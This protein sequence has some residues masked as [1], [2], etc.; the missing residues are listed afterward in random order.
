MNV[1]YGRTNRYYD[2]YNNPSLYHHYYSPGGLSHRL[3]NPSVL[4]AV[5]VVGLAILYQTKGEFVYRMLTIGTRRLSGLYGGGFGSKSAGARREPPGLGNMNNSCYQNSI[6]QSLSS[7]K[8]LPSYLSAIP[9]DPD[10]GR[11][12]VRTAD[13]LRDFLVELNDPANNGRT[14]WTPWVLK[15]MNSWQQQDAQEYYSKILEAVDKDITKAAKQLRQTPS[16]DADV[17]NDDAA[18]PNDDAAVS[19]HSEDSG[20]QS[21]LPPKPN[22]DALLSRNPLE[23]LIAQRVACV[24]CG[25]CD[26]LSTIPFNC[27]TLNL[28]VGHTQHDL[29]ERLDNYTKVEDINGV[30]C[31]KCSLISAQTTIKQILAANPDGYP[32]MRERLA[33]V[34]QALEEDSFDDKTLKRCKIS[35]KPV[36]T[37]KTKQ[38]VIARPPRSL[39]VH[40]SR[41]VFDEQTGYLYKNF[42]PV[43]FPMRL[44]L[45]PWCLGSAGSHDKLAV[46]GKRSGVRHEEQWLVHPRESMVAGSTRPSKI[47]GPIYELRAVVTHYGAHESGHYICYKRT[48][49][50]PHPEKESSEEAPPK[51]ASEGDEGHADEAVIDEEAGE[52]KAV[53]KESE[54]KAADKEGEQR[55]ETETEEA[56]PELDETNK[57]TTTEKEPQPQWWRISDEDVCPVDE[58]EVLYQGSAVFMLFYDCVDPN[59]TLGMEAKGNDSD[60]PDDCVDPNPT[61]LGMEADNSDVSDDSVLTPDDSVLTPDDS[62]VDAGAQQPATALA[63]SIEGVMLGSVGGT[64]P[65][66]KEDEMVKPA[67]WDAAADLAAMVPLPKDDW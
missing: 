48:V 40:I 27:L 13:T 35:M 34:D 11:S 29:A 43:Q 50:S 54:E 51:L 58:Q 14:L 38:A 36:T 47:K 3:T 56:V 53:D 19:Q 17:P 55:P 22:I 37:T 8:D 4:L 64:M 52:E 45:G 30:E 28:G 6:L 5:L 39:A 62:V 18:V 16:C 24:S 2:S 67:V 25:A 66:K 65:G 21:M 10:D 33:I 61:T 49:P 20:Y 7:L 46:D 44:D 15:S 31:P 32:G 42:A 60:V 57:P 23:G 63:G 41:S 59:P 26:G 9:P 1:E 12:S